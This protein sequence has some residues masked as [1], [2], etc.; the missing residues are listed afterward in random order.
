MFMQ[1]KLYFD[2]QV[3]FAV[4][5]LKNWVW[6][7]EMLYSLEQFH[8]SNLTVWIQF[9]VVA[10]CVSS[11]AATASRLR[12]DRVWEL[13]ISSDSTNIECRYSLY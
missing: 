1:L 10:V 5:C 8:N 9:A 6:V 4:S 12:L 13:L 2:I 3:L 7:Y 11:V